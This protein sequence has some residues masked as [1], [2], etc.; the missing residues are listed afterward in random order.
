MRIFDA[1]SQAFPPRPG[2]TETHLPDLT[3]K[4]CIPSSS[5]PSRAIN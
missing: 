1:I 3:G 2:F 4:V 5:L